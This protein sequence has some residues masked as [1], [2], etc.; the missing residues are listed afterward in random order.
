MIQVDPSLS[1]PCRE[2]VKEGGKAT[3]TTGGRRSM[4][5]EDASGSLP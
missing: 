5:G 1:R 3:T 2:D 4:K